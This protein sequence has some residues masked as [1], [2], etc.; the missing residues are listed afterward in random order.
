M[1]GIYAVTGEY[2]VLLSEFDDV[3]TDKQ[4]I[5]YDNS[6]NILIDTTKW[7]TGISSVTLEWPA[8]PRCDING[9]GKTGLEEAIH[10]LKM[11]TGSMP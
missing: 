2:G 9:D 8:M 3:H 7:D 1:S 5:P 10:A 6:D 11:L 4:G